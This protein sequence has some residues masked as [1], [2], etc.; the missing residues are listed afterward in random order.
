MVQ[1]HILLASGWILFC[2]LHSILASPQIKQ[3]LKKHSSH[4]HKYYRLYYTIFAF[5]SLAALLYFQIRMPSL[6]LFEKNKIFTIAG[7]FIILCGSII[8]GICIRKYFMNLS[9]L[10]LLMTEKPQ[11]KTLFIS[12]THKYVRHPLYLGTF[13]FI[14]GLFL[15][16][17]YISLFI[18]NIIITLY[19]LY[20]IRLEE[21]KLVKE[22]GNAYLA[23]KKSVPA[24]IPH[25][26][27]SRGNLSRLKY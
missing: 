7:A 24:L 27:F 26:K 12:G 15:V 21:A 1:Q 14:W 18:A 22:F 11:T 2:A 23:Y 3:E 10:K 17:P 5:I 13:I 6:F 9:G 16:Y 8:M 25:F 20:G 19:T 4:L